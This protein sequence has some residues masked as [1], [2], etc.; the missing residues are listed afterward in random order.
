MPLHMYVCVCVGGRCKKGG[1]Y[2]YNPNCVEV[3]R[4]KL[5]CDVS[6]HNFYTSH[7]CPLSFPT[8]PLSFPTQA[9]ARTGGEAQEWVRY[10]LTCVGRGGNA[11]AVR[12][13]I[14]N[15]MHRNKYVEVVVVVCVCWCYWG[16]CCTQLLECMGCTCRSLPH[17]RPTQ[18]P[19]NSSLSHTH[20]LHNTH[21]HQ[22]S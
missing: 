4:G 2:L 22:D 17:I 6:L 7:F 8:V 16:C 5:L 18:A 21:H 1:L 20:P 19:H 14:L 12:D 15:I 3:D 10:M 13:E 9:Y 11:Q